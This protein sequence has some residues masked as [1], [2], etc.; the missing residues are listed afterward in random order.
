MTQ[1]TTTSSIILAFH[2]GRGGHYHNEGFL[3]YIGTTEGIGEYTRDLFLHYDQCQ[4]VYDAINGR[5]NLEALYN[6]AM[7]DDNTD[8]YNRLKILGLDLGVKAWHNGS[9]DGVGLTEEEAELGIGTI[10]KDG[11]YDT[12]YTKKIED[13]NDKEIKLIYESNEWDNDSVLSEIAEYQQYTPEAIEVAM[14]NEKWDEL[15][16]A[17]DSEFFLDNVIIIGD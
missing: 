11:G 8:A 13:L 1:T 6:Q 17:P 7:D 15:F 5:E 4:E 10:D 16:E 2:I 12:T 14:K 9:G 3:S